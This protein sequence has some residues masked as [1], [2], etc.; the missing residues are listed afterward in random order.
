MKSKFFIIIFSVFFYSIVHSEN[1]N[2]ESKEIILDKNKNTSIFENKVVIDTSDGKKIVSDFAEYNKKQG[3]VKLKNNII[4]T[5][6]NNNII[7]TDYAEY[8]EKNRVFKTKGATKI[9]TTENYVVETNDIVFDNK[10]KFISS[11]KKT[12]INDQSNNIIYLQSFEYEIGTNIFKSLENITVE[13]NKKNTY[14]FSQI[15]ID[16][17]KKEILGTDIKAYLN[18]KEFKIHPENQPRIFANTVSLE[19]NE[20]TFDKSIFTL[21]NYREKDKCPPWTIQS[22]KMFHDSKKKTIYYDN[23]IIKIYDLPIFYLPRFSHPDPSVDRRSGFLSPAFYESKNLGGGLSIPYF[24]DLGRDKNFTL[25]NRFYVSENPLFMGEYH[26]AFKNSNL[27]TDFGFTEGYKKTSSTK[28]AGDKSHLFLNFFKNFNLNEKSKNTLNLSAQHVSNDKYLKLY[29]IKSNLVD[30]NQN[31]LENTIDFTHEEDD[32]FLGINTTIYESLQEDYEDKYEYI[33]P[34][35]TLSKN[36]INDQL[37]GNLDLQSNLEV[38]NYDTN[39]LTSFFV[40]DF[41]WSSKNLFLDKGLSSKFLGNIR[42]INY[43]AKNIDL[44]KRDYTNEVHGA[45]GLI[46]KLNLEKENGSRKHSLIPKILLRFS[47]GSM[48]KESSG[49]KLNP[50]KAFNLNK[51]DEKYNYEKSLSATL[52]LDYKT[53]INNFNE[54]DFSIAQVINQKENKKMA[55]VTSMDEKLSDLVGSVSFKPNKKS[56]IKLNFALDQNYQDINYNEVETNFNFDFISFDFNYLS[57]KKHIGN[58][59]Y[60]KTKVKL[61]N[62]DDGL[63]AFETKRNLVTNSAEFYDLSYEYMNDCLRAG[64]VYRREFYNDSELEPENS[65]MFKV[66]LSTFGNVNSPNLAQ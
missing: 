1:L 33:F 14:R 11:N 60:F 38:R 41:N 32:L 27:L 63:F 3:F 35:A 49:S 59:N 37:L 46:S 10:K 20:R 64:L 29:K 17:K 16:T 58:K 21:C 34:N 54:F 61:K 6:K 8:Y 23:A 13:D 25:T 39:K 51:L 40:N 65:L 26:K 36:L 56:N 4:V 12:K 24:F 15:Y 31:S 47:P 45:L 5:D 19:R 53:K 55:S 48:R 52:G 43:E 66:T 62:N 22:S 9:T 7:E 28:K 50:S 42:N 57:E 30:Y 2:I 44:Y 18:S